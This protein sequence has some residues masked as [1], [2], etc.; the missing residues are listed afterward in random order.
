MA[1]NTDFNVNPYYDDYDEDKLYLRMLFKPG[2]AVQ[3][4]ELTQL[5]TILQKQVERFGNHIF[6][7]GSVVT[8]GQT[9]LQ[10]IVSLKI[11][12]EY[13]GASVSANNFA[14][15]II[16]DSVVTPT[17]RAQI[18]KVY[19]ADP[20]TGEPITF[21]LAQQYGD[22]F[23]EGETIQ[24]YN[25]SEANIPEAANVSVDGVGT[26][27]TFSVTEGVYYYEGFFIKNLAQTVAISKYATNGSA[28]IGFEVTESLRSYTSDTSLLDPAQNASNFQAPGS[29]RYKIEL[30]LATRALDS[31]DTSTF[32]EL[33]R[34][35]N[36][37]L[38]KS[39]KNPQYA[40]L[41]DQLARRT[42][43][44]SGN[45]TVRPFLI[46]IENSS[47]NTQNANVIISSGKAYVYG[48]EVEVLAPTSITYPKPRATASLA[49]RR[50]TADYGNYV[51][52]NNM[53]GT[54]P[55]NSLATVD[56]HCV[57]NSRIDVTSTAK[58]SNTKIGTARIRSISYDSSSNI[59]NSSTYESKI[60]LFDINANNVITGNVFSTGNSSNVQIANASTYFYSNVSN[61]YAGARFRITSGP[62]SNEDPKVILSFDSANQSVQLSNEY[63]TRPNV[64]STFAI[65]FEFNDTVSL[66]NID[67]TTRKF[68]T[69]IDDRS[70]DF[71]SQAIDTIISDSIYEPLIFKL[72]GSFIKENSIAD[73]S[74][75][76][77]RLHPSITF[78]SG[79]SET[80]NV[81]T[82]AGESLSTATSSSIV[83]QNYQVFVT[84]PGSSAYKIGEQIPADRIT[85][86]GTTKKITVVGGLNMV[87]NVVATTDVSNPN[88]KTKTAVNANVQFQ[89]VREDIFGNTGAYVAASQGQVQ[90][91]SRL[92]P[93]TPGTPISLYVSD[94]T[95]LNAVFDLQGSDITSAN[96]AVAANVT[97]YYNLN[98]GQKDSYY[99]HA[100]ISLK[101]GYISP[102]G[103]LVVRYNGFTSAGPGFF[104]V[105]SYPTY[106]QIPT[107]SST[108]NGQYRL[109][110]CID[111]RPVR[112]NAT[113]SNGGAN[114]VLFDVDSATSGP[115][116]PEYGSDII[117][118]FNY[119]LPRT[120]KL[121]LNSSGTFEVLLGES[122]DLPVQPKD[123]DQ[124]MTLYILNN[125]PYGISPRDVT[126]Q[127]LN[128]RRYTM[129]DIGG[130]EKRIENLEYY[131]SLSLLEQDTATKQD[132]TILDTTNLPRFKNGILV[133]SFTGHSIGKVFD[134]E[135]SASID[136]LKKE[137]RPTYNLASIPLTFDPTTSINYAK[138]GT[139]ITANSTP[140]SFITQPKASKSLNVNPYNVVNYLGKVELDPPSDTWRDTVTKPDVLVNLA[141]DNDAWDLLFNNAAFTEWGEWATRGTG[142]TTVTA[143]ANNPNQQ[144]FA[145]LDANGN[146]IV[147]WGTGIA[148]TGT[149]TTSTQL[150]QQRAGQSVSFSPQTLTQSIGDR[151][152]DVSIVPFMRNKNVLFT[153]SD[154][155][156]YTDVY[157]FFDNAPVSKYVA[158]AN[159]FILD[160]GNLQYRTQMGNAELA[161][162]VNVSNTT[163]GTCL[164]IKTSNTELFV[165]S[166][167]PFSAFNVAS[168]NVVGLSTGT[169]RRIIGYE[170]Y[171]GNATSATT[172]TV[173]LRNDIIGANNE[174]W[175][176][177]TA[178]S[179]T[180]HIVS[181]TGAGQTKTITAYNVTTRT[182]TVSGTWGTTPD[183][184]SVYT[185]GSPKT[186]RSGDTAG[187]F[188]IPSATF[189][190]GE[191]TFRLIDSQIGD[192]TTSRTNGD[193]KFYAQ[194]LQQ[195]VEET[196]IS[197]RVPSI[198]RVSVNDER[199]I[200]QTTERNNVVV[201]YYDPL[202]QTFLVSPIQYPQGIYIDRV[203]LAFRTKDETVPVTLQ[204]RPAT[205]GYPSSS[206]IYP[207]GTVTLTPDKVKTTTI[208]NFEDPTK[209]TDF[210]FDA[211]VLMQPGEHSFVLISNSN[212]Y[213]TFIAE[214]GRE[215]EAVVNDIVTGTPI[216]DPPYLGQLFLSQNGSTWQP[217]K[218]S[219]MT[220][221]IFRKQFTTGTSK[222]HFLVDAS[223][224]AANTVFD[225]LHL[226]TS[227]VAM[228]NT[229]VSY[230]FKSERA[231]T[232]GL[233]IF[234]PITP[235]QDYKMVDGDGRRVIRPNVNT[236]FNLQ[237]TFATIDSAIS[238]IIDTARFGGLF[239]ENRINNLPLINSGFVIANSGSLYANSSD[240]TV[241]LTGGG[242]TGAV[243]FAT[244]QANAIT[245]IYLT[246]GG[247]GY[248]GSP[249]VTITPASGGGSGAVVSY[250]GE[251]K[252]TGGPAVARYITRN[253]TL[254]DGFESGDLRVYLTALKPA[255]SN[256][257]VYYKIL[258]QA[259]PDSIENKDYQLMTELGNP[260]FVS[261]ND[262][263]FRELT[264]APGVD[265]SANNSVSYLSGSSSYATFK[266]FAIK[267]VMTGTD[268]TNIPKVKDLRAIA[269]PSGR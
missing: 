234:R 110:D 54:P 63:F 159:K 125:A 18:L 165:V 131:T 101:P 53:Y 84:S 212:K 218:A 256:I 10:N 104:T 76:Y 9:F 52:A 196:I 258:S 187:I 50:I 123:K 142:V 90:L 97:S 100:S 183:T 226:T 267:I 227:E 21:L 60:F 111:F 73:M 34:V 67:S 263:D 2:Y 39:Y 202:A 86:N 48:R 169:S 201:G 206:I 222:L 127:Q 248:T 92:L 96:L 157:P 221:Q 147:T 120:D 167:N 26:A 135:Y 210:I 71:A 191:K 152:V 245:S 44:E 49:N 109:R 266:T 208:P 28:L 31:T 240:V 225:V 186:T 70:F 143:K 156:P 29:D 244:V 174:G 182:V 38:V 216:S 126:L 261:I 81:A 217:E 122:S 117:L 14:D 20:G 94:V 154:F 184:T 56:L 136:R 128:T 12:P 158:A 40:V 242:G 55:I 19:D 166:V 195:T 65:D 149:I 199:T 160:T 33:A 130:I 5:Q 262:E 7:S 42:F 232:G 85:V 115:K 1:I 173:Q 95:S 58:I 89:T 35:E 185:I 121:I 57:P 171:S 134:A 239:V 77:R 25:A 179:N 269:L 209:Y 145:G 32:I 137:L 241:T 214:K 148:V 24:T 23:Q 78:S 205:N 116:I 188:F 236:S 62:G 17:K 243:A 102:I 80:L 16:V 254:R 177:Q 194:G 141:G 260:N 224:V 238:P 161:N 155:K 88:E 91:T 211:P 178:N 153:G 219:S 264:F 235:L 162:I 93:R 253:V 204:L 198:Q 265:G 45:Y 11:D 170:H 252:K 146:P 83:A 172:S 268:T 133:D 233:S 108:K 22:A 103:P 27:Q 15:Q 151:V 4:R 200:T 229:S 47:A 3:A 66:V 69:D 230:A 138:N 175:I 246:E 8:G 87:A 228:Q 68:A 255:G 132:L 98:N 190:T 176:G 181:G 257:L 64:Q 46:R 118:D 207:Y 213:E 250:N 36:G 105:D 74:Y 223:Y 107:Y 139:L 140:V 72:E 189:K 197:T 163:I 193:A 247:S 82:S 79:E 231:E 113:A 59:A 168:M 6:K 51:F 43:D 251:D 144:Q 150:N 129:R 75:S 112:L 106:E 99:D 119:Y 61:A 41:E 220:F 259:D 114:T 192:I 249:T 124:A 37:Q 237:V 13:L 30:V 180:I 203:R 164:T 215:G